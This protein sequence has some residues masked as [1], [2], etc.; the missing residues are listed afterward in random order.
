MYRTRAIITSS[1]DFRPTFPCL[2]HKLSNNNRSE[3]W[4]KNVQATVYNG[5]RT[6]C[7][8]IVINENLQI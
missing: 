8:V 4:G 1:A 6:V 5:A 2:V 3:K 7:I